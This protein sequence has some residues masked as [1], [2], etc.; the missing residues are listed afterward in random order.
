M[1]VFNLCDVV[2]LQARIKFC[3]LPLFRHLA[4]G[5]SLMRFKASE[6]LEI[7]FNAAIKKRQLKQ[8]EGYAYHLERWVDPDQ[9]ADE[10]QSARKSLD[11]SLTLADCQ[12]DN[13]PLRFVLIREH[14]ELMLHFVLI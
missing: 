7:V 4:Q 10:Q 6:T 2:I 5:I 1:S 14:S 13:M 3:P 12:R 8:H 9:P 11:L